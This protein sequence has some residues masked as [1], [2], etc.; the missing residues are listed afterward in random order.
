MRRFELYYFNIPCA[1]FRNVVIAIALVM[2]EMKPPIRGTTK[3]A[4]LE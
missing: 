1:M 4:S 2:F 3:Y